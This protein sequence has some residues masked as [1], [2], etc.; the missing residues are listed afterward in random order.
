MQCNEAEFLGALEA[1]AQSI[2]SRI[3]IFIDAINE[4]RG[5]YFWPDHIKSFIRSFEKYKWLGLVLSI[6]SSY[7]NLIVPREEITDDIAVR[8][9][10]H[11]FAGVEYKAS[12]LFF[13]NYN[14]EQP[15][16]PFL[17]PEFQSP[18]FLKLFCDGLKKAGRTSIPDGYEG[19]SK[20]INFYLEAINRQLCEPKRLDYP[21]SIN[22]VEKA[23]K[24]VVQ[25]MVDKDMR[26]LPYEEAYDLL[27]T[28]LKKYSDKKQL[29][30]ELLSEGLFAK[31]LFWEG[32][33][34]S[35]EVVISGV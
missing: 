32:N 8:L 18:L 20:I 23:T 13:K 21:G 30:D 24:S 35:V 26:H 29:L 7:S 15:S 6:R 11:G 34:K 14:I 3:I 1:K 9:T 25:R 31:N 2:G 33:N 4:G 10:H 22:L 19:I 27:E 12:R 16:V 28:E 17:H 5:R